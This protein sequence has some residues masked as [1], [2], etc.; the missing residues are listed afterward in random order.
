MNKDRQYHIYLRQF[1]RRWYPCIV[2]HDLQGLLVAAHVANKEQ[3]AS[4]V[5]W[6]DI[7][8]L[9]TFRGADRMKFKPVPDTGP[10]RGKW[11][12]PSG[13]EV[14]YMLSH[15][16]IPGRSMHGWTAPTHNLRRATKP[17]PKPS[18]V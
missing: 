15:P 16:D 14:S 9:Q 18:G 13:P 5:S 6:S 4:T 8:Q 3:T 1:D 7:G 10:V 17:N 2:L 12:T 11:K